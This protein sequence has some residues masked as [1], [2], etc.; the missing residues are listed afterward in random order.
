M[1]AWIYIIKTA[2]TI[3]QE[4]VRGTYVKK[5][6]FSSW[7]PEHVLFLF[8]V[9]RKK[10]LP[11]FRYLCI[12]V[13][14]INMFVRRQQAENVIIP[15]WMSQIWKICYIISPQIIRPDLAVLLL[16]WFS[17]LSS[18]NDILLITNFSREKRFNFFK[19]ST[20]AVRF[21]QQQKI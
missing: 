11:Y 20:R 10:L 1:Q 16:D 17:K 13:L 21:Q 12:E 2:L 3:H 6:P 18:L 7:F 8:L 4:K 19:I 9:V 15:D 5:C 14:S